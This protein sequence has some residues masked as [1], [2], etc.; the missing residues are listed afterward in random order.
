[1]HKKNVNKEEEEEELRIK[2]YEFNM[3]RQ[4]CLHPPAATTMILVH[5]YQGKK[6]NEPLFLSLMKS[7]R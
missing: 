3:I 6:Y 4:D 5:Y 1:M 2:T 7:H